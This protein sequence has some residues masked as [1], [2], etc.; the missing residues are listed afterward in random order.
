MPNVNTNEVER[1]AEL[2]ALRA[3]ND[4]LKGQLAQ[5]TAR[6]PNVQAA[7]PYLTEGERQELITFGRSGDLN[8]KTAKE[9]FP[10][11]DLSGAT[12]VARKASTEDETRTERGAVRGVDFV[13]PSVRPGFI[14]PEVAGTPG[15]NGPAA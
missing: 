9:R 1:Q 7:K 3:E 14:D 11:A 6:T 10:D 2:A 15:I 5:A 4:R 13:Y 8:L 12:D